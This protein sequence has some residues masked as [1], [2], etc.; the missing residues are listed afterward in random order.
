MLR[1]FGW[2]SLC[3]LKI[4]V[5][6]SISRDLLGLWSTP[7]RQKQNRTISTT[8]YLHYSHLFFHSLSP[9]K[10]SVLA[11][12]QWRYLLKYWEDIKAEGMVR[13]RAHWWNAAFLIRAQL[14]SSVM[15]IYGS[16][17]AGRRWRVQW[18]PFPQTSQRHHISAGDQLR[19][20]WPPRSR[21]WGRT[22]W[23]GRPRRGRQ[24]DGTRGRT[25]RKG[26][27]KKTQ[28]PSLPTTKV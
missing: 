13:S 4:T 15:A 24:Q 14:T 19:R 7:Q 22:W 28:L 8:R 1:L 16:L 2:W 12:T 17:S 18:P 23:E 27:G 21:A 11:A 20:P 25:F 3:C 6:C 9:C 5:V 10:C 26:N